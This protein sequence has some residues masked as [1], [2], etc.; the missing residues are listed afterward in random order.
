MAFSDTTS[1]TFGSAARHAYGSK[2]VEISTGIWALHSGDI[3]KDENLD[4]LDLGLVENDIS[5]LLFGCSQ[6]I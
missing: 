2:Q 5:S 6:P 4:L 3:A 1:N